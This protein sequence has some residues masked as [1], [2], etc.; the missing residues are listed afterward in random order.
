MGTAWEG[1]LTSACDGLWRVV[2]DQQD[3]VQTQELPSQAACGVCE[4]LNVSTKTC[5]EF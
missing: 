2:S 5:V 3:Q 1:E 4:C